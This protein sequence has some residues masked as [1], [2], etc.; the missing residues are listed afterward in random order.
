MGNTS[1]SAH[2]EVFNK[3]DLK[4]DQNTYAEVKQSCNS[5]SSS[6][7]V[8][9]IKDSTGV[10]IKDVTQE[11]SAINMCLFDQAIKHKPSSAAK[12]ALFN[13]LAA[14]GEATGGFPAASSQSYQYLRN[15]ISQKVSQDV[16]A[17][18]IQECV[19][20]GA[21]DNIIR[22]VNTHGGLLSNIKQVNQAFD[23]CV[24]NATVENEAT[25]D[26]AQ[27]VTNELKAE[28]TAKGMQWAGISSSG[29][30]CCFILLL[31]A[32]FIGYK[33]FLEGGSGGNTYV[34]SRPR[35]N[36]YN[37]ANLEIALKRLA[38]NLR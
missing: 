27:I 26:V 34:N 14:K 29:S 4:L 35:Q 8:L 38:D 9:E 32:A 33:L 16:Y 20:S 21:R 36:S 18:I 28:N 10:T 24:L 11:N 22:V 1:T 31:V 37:D 2:Q 7:N 12:V 13:D 5:G 3:S 23:E 25:T 6:S 30:C 19:N 17:N 15:Q